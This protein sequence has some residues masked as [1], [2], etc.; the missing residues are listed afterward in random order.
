MNSQLAGRVPA[1]SAAPPPTRGSVRSRFLRILLRDLLW[2]T[3]VIAIVSGWWRDH[4][5]ASLREAYYQ[6]ELQETLGVLNF[7]EN[8]LDDSETFDR[9]RVSNWLQEEGKK[10]RERPIEAPKWIWKKQGQG[11]WR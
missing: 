4:Y 1:P 9:E 3:L 5:A 7:A 10:R 11:T 6:D 8:W 2:L